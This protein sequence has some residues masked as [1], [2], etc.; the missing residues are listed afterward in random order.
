MCLTQTGL[1]SLSHTCAN[2]CIQTTVA[3]LCAL[4]I[5]VAP[6]WTGRAAIVGAPLRPISAEELI[7]AAV[8]AAELVTTASI[9]RLAAARPS[10]ANE[11]LKWIH[12]HDQFRINFLVVCLRIGFEIL[13][14]PVRSFRSVQ[15]TDYARALAHICAG[16]AKR[17]DRTAKRRELKVAPNDEFRIG[18]DVWQKNR[19]ILARSGND[20]LKHLAAEWEPRGESSLPER[21]LHPTD[22]FS[23]HKVSLKGRITTQAKRV[24]DAQGIGNEK[25]SSRE[26]HWTNI[27]VD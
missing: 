27:K 6:E 4:W 1:V 18:R 22:D 10:A 16:R 21:N 11:G 13:E 3:E 20:A 25:G 23:K 17:A 8:L 7:G 12:I 24:G 9:G 5:A 2:S 19:L 15:R 14:L 26:P